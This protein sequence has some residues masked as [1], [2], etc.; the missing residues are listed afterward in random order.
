MAA[1]DIP[2]LEVLLRNDLRQVLGDESRSGPPPGSPCPREGE[3]AALLDGGAGA[4]P[5]GVLSHLADCPPCRHRL[6]TFTRLLSDPE[7]TLA[8]RE[9]DRGARWPMGRIPLLATAASAAVLLVFASGDGADSVGSG[10]PADPST[11]ELLHRE[12]GI[13][14][15]LA[16]RIVPSALSP[17]TL[18]WTTVPRADRYQIL[19]FDREGSL[20]WE[21]Q[22]SDTA[23]AL[24]QVLARRAGTYVWKVEAR[25][26]WDRWV[27]SDWQTLTIAP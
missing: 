15:T 26:G 7:I 23:V 17:D 24:P 12:R 13:T 1:S 4:V 19:M 20:V 11:T 14:T 8:Q 9:S 3:L 18:Q 10:P 22:T 16:P 5:P 27:A 21:D 25:T 2:T 6:A